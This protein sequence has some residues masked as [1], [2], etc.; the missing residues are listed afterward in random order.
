[1]GRLIL[2]P[3]FLFSQKPVVFLP[4]DLFTIYSELYKISFIVP[5]YTKDTFKGGLQA[6]SLKVIH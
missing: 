6:P 1:M 5:R 3:P 2:Q 4:K